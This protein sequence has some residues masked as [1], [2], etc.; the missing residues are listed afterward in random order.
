MKKETEPDPN[1]ISQFAD[2]IANR[3][4][5][6]TDERV[7]SRDSPKNAL[8]YRKRQHQHLNDALDQQRWRPQTQAHEK[9]LVPN[10]SNRFH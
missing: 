7:D 4:R 6:F 8:C 10:K 3:R 5:I 1:R 2:G 9:N